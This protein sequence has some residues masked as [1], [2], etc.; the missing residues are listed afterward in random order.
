MSRRDVSIVENECNNGMTNDGV[1]QN[2]SAVPRRNDV[3]RFGN[4]RHGMRRM[5]HRHLGIEL[6]EIGASE[7]QFP[8]R[9]FIA[10]LR[11]NEI[12]IQIDDTFIQRSFSRL[13]VV[14]ER[15][16]MAVAVKNVGELARFDSLRGRESL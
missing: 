8:A 7:V 16:W 3:R 14:S 10:S 13:L 9:F 12:A 5:T 11:C 2:R 4:R 6:I 1:L 15:E